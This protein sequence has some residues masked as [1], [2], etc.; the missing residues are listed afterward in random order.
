MVLIV[1]FKD[2]EPYE[3]LLTYKTPVYKDFDV[4][5]AVLAIVLITTVITAQIWEPCNISERSPTEQQTFTNGQLA[6][7]RAG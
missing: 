7:K 5:F 3:L 4:I 2:V 6:D 1:L